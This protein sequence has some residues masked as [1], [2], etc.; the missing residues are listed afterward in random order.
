[1]AL[2]QGLQSLIDLIGSEPGGRHHVTL[3]GLALEAPEGGEN[4]VLLISDGEL[5][6]GLCPFGKIAF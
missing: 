5:A 1:M 2:K 4:V 6:H 3:G